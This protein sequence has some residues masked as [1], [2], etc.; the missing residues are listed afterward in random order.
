[1]RFRCCGEAG[2]W[3][4]GCSKQAA[5]RLGRTP[6][7]ALNNLAARAGVGAAASKPS[8]TVIAVSWALDSR[9]AASPACIQ[10][11]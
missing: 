11:Y 4:A 10:A 5:R 7:A 1:M 2:A 8:T 9:L 6:P 3:A